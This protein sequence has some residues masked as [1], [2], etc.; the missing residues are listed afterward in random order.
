M[1]NTF[2]FDGADRLL[3]KALAA[4]RQL[5]RLKR[6]AKAQGAPVIY[7]N[8]HYGHWNSSFGDTLERA[9]AS[10]GRD[11][12]DLLEPDAEDYSVLKPQNSGFYAT[13]LALLLAHLNVKRLIVGGVATNICVLYTVQ[14]ARMRQFEVTVVSDGVAA[15]DEASHRFAL[16][17]M[18]QFLGASVAPAAQVS[19]A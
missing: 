16:E 13:P 5:G 19:F 18:R 2:D 7:V 9:R 4:A 8:D 12:I 17:Q 14:D 11:I 1:I 3:P 6:E 10:A 15:E